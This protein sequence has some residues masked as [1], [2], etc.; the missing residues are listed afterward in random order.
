[1]VDSIDVRPRDRLL[2]HPGM[3]ALGRGRPRLPRYLFRHFASDP[4]RWT[5]EDIELFLAPLRDPAVARAATALYRGFIQP[6]ALRIVGD[7]YRKTRL[8][9]PTRLLIGADEPVVRA[10]FL[11]GHEDHADDLAI[12]VVDAPR[13][14]WSTSG[15]RPSPGAPWNC[16]PEQV[17]TDEVTCRRQTGD[18]ALRKN[19]CALCRPI[20]TSALVRAPVSTRR[21]ATDERHD[22]AHPPQPARPRRDHQCRGG[23]LADDRGCREQRLSSGV[24]RLAGRRRQ[25]VVPRRQLGMT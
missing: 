25:V 9:T 23:C 10:E 4:S 19:Y 15:R 12:E 6:E 7:S 16:S 11:G 5:Y 3:A 14:G 24:Q 21:S 17:L 1:M 22:Y 13:T 8:T 2:V 18:N 20:A